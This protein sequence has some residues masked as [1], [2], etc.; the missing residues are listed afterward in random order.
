L[1]WGGGNQA[2]QVTVLVLYKQMAA[3][4]ANGS[5]VLMLKLMRL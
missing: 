1:A 3:G 5:K 4:I 2:P